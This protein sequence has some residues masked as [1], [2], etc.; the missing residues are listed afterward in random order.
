MPKAFGDP[1]VLESIAG[2][3]ETG[4]S[5]EIRRSAPQ[6]DSHIPDMA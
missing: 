6:V 3:V 4:P 1:E 5:A 2:Q